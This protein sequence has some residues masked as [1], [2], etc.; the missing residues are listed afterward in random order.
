MFW[1]AT[2]KNSKKFQSFIIVV[3]AGFLVGILIGSFLMLIFL[4]SVPKGV[5][6]QPS[7][8]ISQIE[9][10]NIANK[11]ANQVSRRAPIVTEPVSTIPIVLLQLPKNLI[12][13]MGSDASALFLDEVSFYES[14]RKYLNKIRECYA[15]ERKVSPLLAGTLSYDV[16]VTASGAVI[17]VILV[18]RTLASTEVI[19]CVTGILKSGVYRRTMKEPRTF[20]VTLVFQ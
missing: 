14:L 10:R 5:V 8:I 2:V 17:D 16:T 11:V 15:A 13:H 6:I 9:S 18:E 20:E 12:D 1:Q 4:P 3:I 19:N 7:P